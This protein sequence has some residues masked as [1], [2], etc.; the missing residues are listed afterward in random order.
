MKKGTQI[1][2]I[3]AAIIITMVAC[4]SVGYIAGRGRKIAPPEPMRDTIYVARE[5]MVERPA[6]VDSNRDDER[7]VVVPVPAP[8]TSLA[9]APDTL[10]YEHRHYQR[11]SVDVWASGYDVTIDS[12]RVRYACPVVTEKVVVERC[13]ETA[14]KPVSIYATAGAI[15]RGTTYAVVGAGVSWQYKRLTIYGEGGYGADFRGGCGAY[16]AAGIRFDIIRAG[17]RK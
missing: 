13:P 6:L 17:G 14:K 8:D 16:A 4:A 12:V 9:A 5:I 7:P 10:S 11:D 15:Y 2:L 3:S 1:G